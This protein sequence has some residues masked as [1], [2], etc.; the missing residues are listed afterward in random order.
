MMV[1]TE[2]TPTRAP[3]NGVG[4]SDERLEARLDKL[5]ETLGQ[6]QRDVIEINAQ[7]KSQQEAFDTVG[8]TVRV[9]EQRFNKALGAIVGV[10]LLITLVLQVVSQHFEP[11]MPDLAP[12]EGQIHDVDQDLTEHRTVLREH[13]NTHPSIELWQEIRMLRA[14]MDRMD[15]SALDS[16]ER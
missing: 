14:R 7:Q 13:I 8:K 10:P 12:I 3:Q 6:L 2:Q 9:H 16:E 5:Q 1:S 15:R 4:M 11:K